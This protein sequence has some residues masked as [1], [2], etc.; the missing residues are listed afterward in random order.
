MHKEK[1]AAAEAHEGELDDGEESM[2]ETAIDDVTREI[3]E[4]EEILVKLKDAVKG[5]AVMKHEYE[6][7]V[8]EINNLETERHELEA[9]LEKAKKQE[10]LLIAQKK[11]GNPVVMEKMKERFLKVKDEL[12]RMKADK[13][14]KES[15]YNLMQRES[16]Q[17]DSLQRELMKL[18]ENKVALMRVQ[19]QQSQQYQKFR[20]EQ[21]QK[22][23]AMKKSDV[24]KQRQ[25][26]DLKSELQKKVRV[27]GNKDREIGRIQSKLKACET[28]IK[29]LMANARVNRQRTIFTP[30]KSTSG[31]YDTKLDEKESTAVFASAKNILD[32]VIQDRVEARHMRTLYQKKIRMLRDIKEELA[33]EIQEKKSLD[34]Q[35]EAMEEDKFNDPLNFTDERGEALSAIVQQIKTSDATIDRI[36]SEQNILNADVAELSRKVGETKDESDTTWEE[37]GKNAISGLTQT[38]CQALLWEMSFDKAELLGSLQEEQDKLNDTIDLYSSA[39]ERNEELQQELDLTIGNFKKRLDDAEKQRVQD[40]WSVLQGQ[41]GT[42]NDS[43]AG[44]TE[45]IALARAQELENALGDMVSTEADLRA[46]IVEL[47]TKNTE[48][49][50]SLQE[51]IFTSRSGGHLSCKVEAEEASRCFSELDSIWDSAWHRS[52]GEAGCPDCH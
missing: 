37:I 21:T 39:S 29:H 23:T 33:M 35:R 24:K 42:A 43:V 36:T 31:E 19:K 34:V 4:K 10:E 15:A 13:Q 50:K 22:M 26:N 2:N 16:K 49:Q 47:Q 38:Q 41:S 25:M 6:S 11:P 32:N 18:K 20:K 44:A 8:H 48:L 1:E 12:A 51:K 46:E 30:S 17:C 9:A 45:S 27:L 28:H 3:V 40:I 7:L 5:F 52:H 14:K